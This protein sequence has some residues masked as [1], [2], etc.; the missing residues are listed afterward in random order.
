MS[1]HR[2]NTLTHARIAAGA[3]LPKLI[4]S[5]GVSKE[6]FDRAAAR[7]AEG[8][9]DS[10]TESS[11]AAEAE[12]DEDIDQGAFEL[13]TGS[14]ARAPHVQAVG[15]EA[16]SDE[17]ATAEHEE[18]ELDQDAEDDSEDGKSQP[19]ESALFDDYFEGDEDDDDIWYRK[20][21]SGDE[22]G[23]YAGEFEPLDLGADWL[24]GGDGDEQE[25]D[26]DD[27]EG[28]ARDSGEVLEYSEE[29]EEE[30]RPKKKARY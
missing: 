28:V 18:L 27:D 3:I 14:G 10:D 21:G 17:Y 19:S 29:D 20:D 8:R 5:A 7:Y 13:V 1:H 9:D 23:L 26:D 6:D 12:Q 11:S 2:M 22:N 16:V 15:D 30:V 4:R 24:D 25:D